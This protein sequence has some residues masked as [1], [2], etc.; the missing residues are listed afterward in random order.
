MTRTGIMRDKRYMNH[1]AGAFHPESPQRL[2]AIYGM[3][4]EPGMAGFFSRVER[5][6]NKETSK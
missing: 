6:T 3:L 5:V 1:E 4:E 2:E